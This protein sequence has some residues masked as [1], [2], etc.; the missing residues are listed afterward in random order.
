M[1]DHLLAGDIGGTNVR[2][3]LLTTDGE[4][5]A[6]EACAHQP[7][8][9]ALSS[10]RKSHLSAPPLAAAFGCAGGV[11]DG[12]AHFVARKNEEISESLLAKAFAMPA[13]RVRLVNDMAAHMG[14]LD[15]S[16]F[17]TLRPGESHGLVEA[18]VMPGTGLGCGLRVD[19]GGRWV[20]IGTEGGQVDGVPIGWFD[21]FFD[22]VE[23]RRGV[24]RLTWEHVVAAPALSLLFEWHGNEGGVPPE[25][26][27]EWSGQEDGDGEACHVI[28]MFLSLLGQRAGNLCLATGAT[29]GVWLG[30]G[31]LNAMH[32]AQPAKFTH[33]VEAFTHC[34]PDVL[35]GYMNAVPLRLLTTADSGLRGAAALAQA[36]LRTVS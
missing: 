23:K 17:V 24:D 31:L 29:R 22:F 5:V 36:M 26:I 1:P 10:F 19:A 27:V 7:V 32:A 13:S 14:G 16:E 28:E 9:E 6:E 2:L 30:G 35:R 25:Q 20:A 34:G 33:V 15:A 4:T 8:G 3:R 18:M 11:K 12:E 21:D